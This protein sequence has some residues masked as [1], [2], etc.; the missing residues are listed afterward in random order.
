[1]RGGW[2]I[3]EEEE[4]LGWVVDCWCLLCEALLAF[5]AGCEVLVCLYVSEVSAS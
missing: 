2:W 1:M 5:E 3:C 4:A